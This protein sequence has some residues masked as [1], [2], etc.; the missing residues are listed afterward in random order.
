MIKTRPYRQIAGRYAVLVAVLTAF[1]ASPAGAQHANQA[2]LQF[3]DTHFVLRGSSE[4]RLEFLPA[5]ELDEKNWSEMLTLVYVPAA[6][7]TA[8][9]VW[10]KSNILSHYQGSG[11]IYR[12][13]QIE[14]AEG[15]DH[16]I[17]AQIKRGE[18]I[19]VIFTRILM[20]DEQGL[21][22]VFSHRFYGEEQFD[23]VD[24]WFDVN[25]EGV[26]ATL[27]GLHEFPLAEQG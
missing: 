23:V 19:E 26:E 25:S 27:L 24:A 17:V 22:V 10:V 15:G 20:Y 21:A 13:E 12:S 18:I 16:L 2:G 4:N 11:T 6:T 5:G 3:G 14:R 1:C 8:D 9:L 7:A